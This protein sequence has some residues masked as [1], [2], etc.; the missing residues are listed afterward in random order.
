MAKDPVCNMEV[1]ETTATETAEYLEE[2]YYFC[3]SSC[4]E[5]FEEAPDVYVG[6]DMMYAGK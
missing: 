5:A 2:K 3:S 1:D 6:G 4:R